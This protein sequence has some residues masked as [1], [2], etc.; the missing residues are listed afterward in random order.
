MTNQHSPKEYGKPV[1]RDP[2]E[3]GRKMADKPKPTKPRPGPLAEV[4]IINE[5]PETAL[6]KLLKTPVK[7]TKTDT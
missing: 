1:Y 4:L 6:S 7:P 2:Y 3:R 5:D